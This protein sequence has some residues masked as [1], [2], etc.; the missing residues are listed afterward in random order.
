MAGN[1]LMSKH[2]AH[3]PFVYRL[4]PSNLRDGKP[5]MEPL[6]LGMMSNG[7]DRAAA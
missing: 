4:G 3:L 7:I 1:L 6:H 2:T 5:V